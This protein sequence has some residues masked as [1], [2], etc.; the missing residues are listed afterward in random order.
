MGIIPIM[1]SMRKLRI[2]AFEWAVIIGLT[3]LIRSVDG[4][5]PTLGLVWLTCVIASVIAITRGV[6]T[7]KLRLMLPKPVA[8]PEPGCDDCDDFLLSTP[9]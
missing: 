1:P 8:T 9:E 4:F 7:G 3:M 6:I 2:I 5:W